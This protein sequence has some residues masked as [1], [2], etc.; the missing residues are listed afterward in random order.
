MI[1]YLQIL[2][3]VARKPLTVKRPPVHLQLEP[4]TY[5]NL[6]CRMCGRAKHFSRSSHLSVEEFTTVLQRIRPRKLT[7][8][9]A[10]EPF[11]NPSLLEM[12]R[13]AKQAGVSIN[14]TTN[15][16]LLSPERCE[17]IVRSG[18]DL[19]KISIDGARPETYLSIRGKDIFLQVLD[20]IRV[21]N[22]TKKRLGSL[23]PF[24]RL[25][26]V[27]SKENYREITE[28]ITLASD[29]EVDAVYFQPLELVG[30]E[31]RQDVLV[32]D[33]RL[34]DLSREIA[35][36]IE[37]SRFHS[38]HTNLAGLTEKLPLYWGKY[39]MHTRGTDARKCI[40][41]W[42]SAYITVDGNVRPCCSFSQTKAD[43][44]NIFLTD[45]E[46]IW[47]GKAYQGLRKAF[48][49]GK[50]PYPICENCVPQTLTDM[51]KSSGILPGFLTT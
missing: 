16:S 13:L 30:I 40:L 51:L 24:L 8:S 49:E 21:L 38:V 31:E 42:F 22:E 17:Q 37:A 35:R 7:L 27:L 5:C 36:A 39:Q 41:P 43:F 45:I 46:N 14:T 11:M 25:N 9:G 26:Y 20:G 28:L 23:K 4:T 34:E 44:G 6:D 18:L 3:Q 10:G 19:L 29:L 50:R 32:G 33:L 47:N 48:R 12:V 1:E 15:G 2:T